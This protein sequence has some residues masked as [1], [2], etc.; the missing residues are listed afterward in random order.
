M[1]V[2][3]LLSAIKT[4]EGS[5]ESLD[6]WLKFWIGLVV[7]GVVVEV[8]VVLVEYFHAYRAFRKAIISSP[9]KPSSW[10][11]VWNLLGASF[12]AVGVAGEL[13]IH[14]R[15]GKIESDLKGFNRALVVLSIRDAGEAK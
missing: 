12:V 4:S 1:N 3:D 6:S 11:L 10:M 7:V 14:V 13:A 8:L 15:A 5:L 2:S 9:E